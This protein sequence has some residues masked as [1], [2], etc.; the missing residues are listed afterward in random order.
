L[1]FTLALY[2]VT[3]WWVGFVSITLGSA[4]FWLLPPRRDACANRNKV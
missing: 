1:T 3:L 2:M 4:G